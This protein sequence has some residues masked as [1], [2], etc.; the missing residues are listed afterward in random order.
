MAAP[1]DLF[2][3]FA[4]AYGLYL[5]TCDIDRTVTETARQT[6]AWFAASITYVRGDSVA[7]LESF[8][9][10]I[11]LLYRDGLGCP[12]DSDATAAQEHNLRE[13]TAAFPHLSDGAVLILDDNRWANSG[14]TRRSKD[15]P[16]AAGWRCLLD[17]VPCLRL[18]P[19]GLT[20]VSFAPVSRFG[21]RSR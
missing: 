18:N 19:T 3:E 11:D 9:E 7:F 15:F 20:K 14:K 13:L 21:G 4:A 2:G 16:H 8:P 12:P 17:A 10:P 6:T 1:P 5:W